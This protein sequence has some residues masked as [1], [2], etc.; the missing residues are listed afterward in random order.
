MDAYSIAQNFA[1][2]FRIKFADS[3]ALKNE[4]YKIR[5]SV[6]AQELGW[7]PCNDAAIETDE[8]DN[9]AFHCLI[10]HKQTATYA[11]CVRLIVPPFD[12]DDFQLPLEKH[13]MASIR[14]NIVDPEQML[15]GSFGEISR[16]AVLASFRRRKNE[17]NTP[18]IVQET[19]SENVYSEHEKR[20]FPNLAIGLYLAA[21]ALSDLC[22]HEGMFVMM[23]PRLNR[24][25]NRFGLPFIQC[26]DEMD[27]HGRRAMFFLNRTGFFSQ[28]TPELLDLYLMIKEDLNDQFSAKLV[29]IPSR[30]A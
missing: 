15:Q 5:Y 7:E 30:Q 20:N 26:G 3:G 8:Y 11:G 27:Y 25:L 2:Y 9:N 22:A 12:Q 1:Q 28:L 6:Y 24:R 21:V 29:N 17:Q 16:L 10:E 4:V 18:Y 23:E 13:C 14:K 19:T